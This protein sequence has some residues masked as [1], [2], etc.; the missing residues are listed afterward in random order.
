[1]KKSLFWLAV[2][3]LCCAMF[4]IGVNAETEGYYSRELR[5]ENG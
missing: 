4:G 2:V 1:M 3:M 5:P